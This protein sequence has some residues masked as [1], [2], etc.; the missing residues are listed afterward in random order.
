MNPYFQTQQHQ[1]QFQQQKYGQQPQHQGYQQHAQNI[2]Q[3]RTP[4]P[5]TYYSIDVEAVATG[6]QHN[7]RSVA[8]ISLIDEHS[9]VL[10]NLYVKPDQPIIS[11]LT[12]LNGITPEIL[13]AH[14]MPLQQALQILRHALPTHAVLVGQN[15]GQDVA[16]LGLKEGKDFSGMMD[17]AGMYQA[18]NTQFSSMSKFSQDHVANVLLDWAHTH[19]AQGDGEHGA[20][21]DALKSIALFHHHRALSATPGALEAAKAA[22]LA[23]PTTLSFARRFPTYEG[24]CM[25]LRRSC[26]CGATFN[27]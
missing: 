10:L 15:I 1:D 26:T 24:V 11:Y 16:W 19:P 18:Y 2:Q 13:D 8:Q 17:L 20:V 23:A 4:P 7:S 25:G 6:V 5:A 14:G 27:L 22:L 3:H 9:N 21:Q 12:P